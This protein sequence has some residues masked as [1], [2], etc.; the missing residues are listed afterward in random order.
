MIYEL[1]EEELVITDDYE[2]DAY[3]RVLVKTKANEAVWV[4]ICE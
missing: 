3:Q 4:Y 2:G 1:D